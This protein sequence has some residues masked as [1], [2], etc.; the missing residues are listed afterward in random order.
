MDDVSFELLK[1]YSQRDRLSITGIAAIC[2]Q[3]A[4]T[5]AEPVLYLAD[6]EYLKKYEGSLKTGIFDTPYMI[7]HAGY[8]ALETELKSRKHFKYS[9]LRAWVALGI[10][11][12]AIMI[13][14]ISLLLQIL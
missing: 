11:I 4:R 9:E 2:N 5:V 3:D 10:S 6:M 7:T 8:T 13:S 1:L 14:V 12:I